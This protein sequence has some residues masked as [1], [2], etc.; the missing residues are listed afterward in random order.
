MRRR[1]SAEMLFWFELEGLLICAVEAGADAFLL[2]EAFFD[3]ATS[4][5]GLFVAL[6][7]DG[8]GV[9]LAVGVVLGTSLLVSGMTIFLHKEKTLNKAKYSLHFWPAG[10]YF[11][12]GI[13]LLYVFSELG[14]M[15]IDL[16]D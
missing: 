16:L 8:G 5:A 12:S 7:L 11:A 15:P 6:A 1:S 9:V 4:F 10:S 13:C 3:A 14:K 2:A